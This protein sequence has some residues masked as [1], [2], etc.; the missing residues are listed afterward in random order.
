MSGE[1]GGTPPENRAKG[2]AGAGR[3]ELTRFREYQYPFMGGIGDMIRELSAKVN[4]AVNII[5]IASAAVM[6]GSGLATA[7]GRKFMSEIH[8]SA[9]VV[10]LVAAAVH[11]V[12]N[13]RQV[14]NVCRRCIRNPKRLAGESVVLL[15]VILAVLM[16]AAVLPEEE[17]EEPEDDC[18]FNDPVVG[19]IATWLH[20][21]VGALASGVL[22]LHIAK[23]RRRILCAG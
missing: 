12:L 14:L 22:L 21:G 11:L 16:T 8:E 4:R 18:A 15:M 13:W 5:G 17:G 3:V 10:F 19:R 1:S 20:V 23:R 9:V 7:L 6:A 2:N